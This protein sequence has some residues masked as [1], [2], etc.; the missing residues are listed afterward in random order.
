MIQNE[1]QYKITKTQAA[2]FRQALAELRSQ[3]SALPPAHARL[4][5]DALK[6]Q[7][8]TLDAEIREYERL[9]AGFFPAMRKQ[10]IV[11][12]SKGLIRARIVRK[13]TQEQLA[14]QLN[15]HPQQIQQYEATGYAGA[16]LERVATI[17][18]ALG[19]T[20][21]LE[22]S[23][24]KNFRSGP[25]KQL[26]RV[27]SKGS[28]ARINAPSEVKCGKLGAEISSRGCYSTRNTCQK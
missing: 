18:D 21:S 5:R 13:M 16:D 28:S 24:P 20:I 1:R 27:S 3:P 19:V 2:R 6:G 10:P 11:A 26:R 14:K 23:T 9:Q 25:A 17:A 7:L 4:E 12:L 22:S 15:L 8:E